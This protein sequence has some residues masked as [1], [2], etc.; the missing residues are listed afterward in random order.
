MERQG[1]IRDV[2]LGQGLLELLRVGKDVVDELRLRGIVVAT[3]VGEEYNR[4]GRIAPPPTPAVAILK[5]GTLG[6][7]DTDLGDIVTRVEAV[8]PP[9]MR[10]EP[11]VRLEAGRTGLDCTIL[12]LPTVGACVFILWIAGWR[13][14]VN[15]RRRREWR[16]RC[17]LCIVQVRLQIASLTKP[18]TS[19]NLPTAR[20][21]AHK[22]T[23][24]PF[25]GHNSI[26]V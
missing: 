18:Y 11:S 26:N 24:A 23:T 22:L 20:T 5:V 19:P 10:G 4:A 16:G 7:G 8:R 12:I 3:P 17:L 6:G 2:V 15:A 21:V 13:C 1:R 25:S 14:S 9:E